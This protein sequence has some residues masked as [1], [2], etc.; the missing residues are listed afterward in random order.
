MSGSSPAR[1]CTGSP[2]R[3]SSPSTA[4]IT[5]RSRTA[6]PGVVIDAI[7]EDGVVEGIEDPRHRFCLGVQWHPEFEISEADRRI[8]RAF[9]EVGRRVSEA[10]RRASRERIAKLLAR[11]GLCS[12]RDA[13]RWIAAGRVAV[14][15]RC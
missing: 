10:R 8:F 12:R 6:G 14:D 2:E 3:Q 1:C 4:P 7:A 5:R 15:G 13:E 11:A 9:I